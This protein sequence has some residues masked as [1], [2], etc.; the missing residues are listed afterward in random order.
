MNRARRQVLVLFCAL[1]ASVVEAQLTVICLGSGEPVYLIGGGPAFSTSN[2]APIQQKLAEHYKTCRWDMRGVG[3]NATSPVS[4]ESPILMQWIADMAHTL[5]PQPVVLWGHSWGALQ[6]LLFA[7]HYPDRVKAMVLNNPVDPALRSLEHIESKRYVHPDV[8][9]RLNIDDIGTGAERLHRFRSKIASYFFDAELGWAY[10]SE[11]SPADSNNELNIQI[12]Q[13]YSRMPLSADDIVN[14]APK[15]SRVIYCRYDVL[16]PE[17]SEEYSRLL[18][19]G[20][21]F[22]IEEC[23]HFPWVEAPEEFYSV[24]LESI[25]AEPFSQ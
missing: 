18:A 21:Q 6:V 14:L 15:I 25:Q 17:N 3:V 8:E 16:M 19:P 11:F 4:T 12:W 1:Y 7:K 20:K 2:L 22:T 24:L 5:P 9:S 10:S 23:A 13:E